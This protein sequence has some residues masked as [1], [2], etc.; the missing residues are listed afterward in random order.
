MGFKVPVSRSVGVKGFKVHFWQVRISSLTYY[1]G[2]LMASAEIGMAL[3]RTLERER[4]RE[5]GGVF[6]VP[7][8]PAR[9]KDRKKERKKERKREGLHIYR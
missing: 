2:K 1:D 7:C 5:T 9:K 6:G 3:D 4:E 8:R